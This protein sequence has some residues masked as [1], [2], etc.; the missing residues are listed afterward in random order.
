MN[1]FASWLV[2]NV[3][4]VSKKKS[5]SIDKFLHN[6]LVAKPLWIENN[7]FFFNWP[8][9][10]LDITISF[11]LITKAKHCKIEITSFFGNLNHF[12]KEWNLFH[13]SKSFNLNL[14]FVLS[15]KLLENFLKKAKLFSL[16]GI[17]KI[18]LNCGLAPLIKEC[19]ILKDLP[20]SEKGKVTS[21]IFASKSNKQISSSLLNPNFINIP[22]EV[23]S[24]LFSL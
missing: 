21:K 18:F 22:H 13:I 15:E 17:S 1:V 6:F 20:F 19:K 8:T 12:I 5:S 2:L 10:T 7:S 11:K 14:S 9:F 3:P 23:L 4:I 16:C 24:I